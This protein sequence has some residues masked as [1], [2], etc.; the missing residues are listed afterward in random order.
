MIGLNNVP[1]PGVSVAFVLTYPN[2]N[3]R[4]VTKYMYDMPGTSGIAAALQYKGTFAT[5]DH[6][7]VGGLDMRRWRLGQ[8]FNIAARFRQ[9]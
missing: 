6:S 4:W 7:K 9:F 5:A 1:L 8:L 2:V 3:V